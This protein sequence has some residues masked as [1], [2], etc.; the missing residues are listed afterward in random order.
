MSR[1]G[2]PESRSASPEPLGSTDSLEHGVAPDETGGKKD[3]HTQRNGG[4]RSAAESPTDSSQTLERLSSHTEDVDKNGR[5]QQPRAK[6]VG[7]R[8]I[9]SDDDDERDTAR[10]AQ[11]QGNAPNPEVHSQNEGETAASDS[12][13]ANPTGLGDDATYTDNSIGLRDGG[14]TSAD[15]QNADMVSRERNGEVPRDSQPPDSSHPSKL[16][17]EPIRTGSKQSSVASLELDSNLKS[18]RTSFGSALSRT[19]SLR[20]SSLLHAPR[21]QLQN[22]TSS[23]LYRYDPLPGYISRCPRVTFSVIQKAISP[24]HVE[25]LFGIPEKRALPSYYYTST[26]NS[27]G[28]GSQRRESPTNRNRNP[29]SPRQGTTKGNKGSLHFNK[30]EEEHPDD[31]SS[32]VSSISNFGPVG[33]TT[34]PQ[35]AR[36]GGRSA[37]IARVT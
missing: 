8:D 27:N 24:M 3:D 37:T 34:R 13:I 26:D 15:N 21:S 5:S 14:R 12:N 4:D 33:R 6:K 19:D 22:I 11:S 1:S 10:T 16:P 35:A 17:H 23:F 36:R 20:A 9:D 32:D 30:N 28:G 29:L 2:S 31:G 18:P 25:L 7:F